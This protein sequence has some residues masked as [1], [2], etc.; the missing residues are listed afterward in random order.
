MDK[1]LPRRFARGTSVRTGCFAPRRHGRPTVR[2][3]ANG[4][5]STPAGFLRKNKPGALATAARG[6]LRQF[7][8]AAVR[9][10]LLRSKTANA[11]GFTAGVCGFESRQLEVGQPASRFPARL[12]PRT[13]FEAVRIRVTS[14]LTRKQSVRL[15]PRRDFSACS[16]TAERQSRK[17]RYPAGF[18][19]RNFSPQPHTERKFPP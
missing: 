18:L 10:G 7:T 11:A 12:S 3:Q 15:R 4:P 6:S 13:I 9:A 8:L 19:L 17:A 1:P 16:S 5:A 14:L 2:V